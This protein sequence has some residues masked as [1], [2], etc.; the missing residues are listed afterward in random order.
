VRAIS[1]DPGAQPDIDHRYFSDP[2]DLDRMIGAAKVAMEVANVMSDSIKCEVLLP[3]AESARDEEALRRHFL[4][5]HATDYHP[6]G[7]LRMGPDGDEM[8]VVDEHCRLRGIDNLYVAD[9]SVM[10]TVPRAN[11]NLPTMMIGERVAEF[12]RADL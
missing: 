2:K 7:T 4:E 9:A 8:A 10:P 11:I 5:Y 3:D 1:R 6:C 12:V